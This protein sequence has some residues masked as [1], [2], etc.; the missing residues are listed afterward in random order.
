MSP[1]F[2]SMMIKKYM[3]KAGIDDPRLTAHS[4]RH[5]FAVSTLVAGAHVFDVQQMLG[6]SD[7]KT[8]NIYLL[9]IAQEQARKGTPVRLL[10]DLFGNGSKQAENVNKQP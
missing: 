9:S 6:H 5:T 2:L 7:I 10:D 8:T 4:L 3:R 1:I